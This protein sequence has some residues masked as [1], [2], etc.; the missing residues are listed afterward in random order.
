MGPGDGRRE[1]QL[2]LTPEQVEGLAQAFGVS[3]APRDLASVT[4]VLNVLRRSLVPLEALPLEGV[5]ESEAHLRGE[6][7]CE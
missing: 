7:P 1:S 6:S 5:E 4:H 2:S 3:V